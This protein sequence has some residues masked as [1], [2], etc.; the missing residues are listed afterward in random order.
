MVDS[1]PGIP[2]NITVLYCDS[3]KLQ[4]YYYSHTHIHILG[5]N[6]L[7]HKKTKKDK[8]EKDLVGVF[9]ILL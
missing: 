1:L 2:A 6:T 5:K 4:F 7:N 3:Y 9:A 8:N